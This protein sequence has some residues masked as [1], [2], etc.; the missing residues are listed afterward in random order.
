[1]SKRPP[2]RVTLG[3][4]LEERGIPESIDEVTLQE[5]FVGFTQVTPERIL[6][7]DESVIFVVPAGQRKRALGHRH[8]QRH[9]LGESL[10]LAVEIVERA[11]TPEGQLRALFTPFRPEAVEVITTPAGLVGHVSLPTVT[12]GRALGRGGRRLKLLRQ[13]ASELASIDKVVVT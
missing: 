1:M 6:T 10:G 3:D 5:L 2:T 9:Q 4:L 8:R 13:L 12:R 7:D 11:E